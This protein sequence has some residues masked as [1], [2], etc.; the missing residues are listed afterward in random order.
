MPTRDTLPE[1]ALLSG[2]AKLPQPQLPPGVLAAKKIGRYSIEVVPNSDRGYDA[3]VSCVVVKEEGSECVASCNA[4]TIEKAMALAE[5]EVT[6]LK[7]QA[8][9]FR[10][11]NKGKGRSLTD[12]ELESLEARRNERDYE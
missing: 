5:V 9:E 1:S 7:E 3:I 2:R 6:K 4:P 8:K 12:G 10:K 11:V